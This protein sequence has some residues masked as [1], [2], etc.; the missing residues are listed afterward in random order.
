[1]LDW[2]FDLINSA[3]Q[4]GLFGFIYSA[5]WLILIGPALMI[6]E[7][8]EQLFVYLAG[9]LVLQLLFGFGVDANGKEI[10]FFSLQNIPPAFIGF[11]ILSITL[12]VIFF[13]INY[14][15]ISV[16]D[17]LEVK[18][19]LIKA[20][21]ASLTG[22][23]VSL[24]MPV[25]IFIAAGFTMIMIQALFVILS[26]G[27]EVT[28]IARILYHIGDMDWDGVVTVGSGSALWAPPSK[29]L[30]GDYNIFIEIAAVCGLFYGMSISIISMAVK[31]FEIF[32]LFI[33]GPLAAATMVNDDGARLKLWKEQIINKFVSMAIGVSIFLVF[34]ILLNTLIKIRPSDVISGAGAMVDIAFLLVII[35]AGASFLI[36]GPSLASQFAGGERSIDKD[37]M[38]AAK[39]VVTASGVGMMA[40]TNIGLKAAGMYNT[41]NRI[42]RKS[43]LSRN[44]PGMGGKGLS[45]VS[46]GEGSISTN[47]LGHWKNR[48]KIGAKIAAGVGIGAGTLYAASKFKNKSYKS[49]AARGKIRKGWENLKTGAIQKA[50]NV[51]SGVRQ[52]DADGNI[53]NAKPLFETKR[54]AA[55]NLNATLER[56]YDK[57]PKTQN[58]DMRLKENRQL[59]QQKQVAEQ[60]LNDQPKLKKIIETDKY[61]QRRMELHERNVQRSKNKKEK[62][63]VAKQES[64]QA[65]KG[66]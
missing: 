51:L 64:K 10:N 42:K 24:L 57:N 17:D 31:S 54:Q 20:I 37:V 32:W 3:L 66:Y 56:K 28:S 26:G 6:I 18:A 16:S 65:K 38:S 8:F 59:K 34:G 2:L 52:I 58:I 22:V 4:S 62:E 13:M 21:K 33:K 45:D 19:R 11:W 9:N 41:A 15:T 50:S 39:G 61:R 23:V 1:M 36:I 47:A 55:M 46:T 12:T 30:S 60:R 25:G 14:C 35:W 7:A 43:N 63:K 5:I 48:F 49:V 29:M 40:A 44:V 27:N 53:I